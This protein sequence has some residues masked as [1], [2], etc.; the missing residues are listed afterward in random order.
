MKKVYPVIR[1]SRTARPA[2][3][4]DL[5]AKQGLN[6]IFKLLESLLPELPGKCRN[7]KI[8]AFMGKKI[9]RLV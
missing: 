4:P 1:S 5:T 6:T 7:A 2:A 8:E 3:L 9:G